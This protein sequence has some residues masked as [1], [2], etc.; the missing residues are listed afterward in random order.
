[1]V[2]QLL[3]ITSTPIEY[4][5]KIEPARLEFNQADNP[6]GDLSQQNVRLNL[7]SQNTQ[8]RLDTMDMRRTLG[9]QTSMDRAYAGAQKGRS[10]F[11]KFLAEQTQTAN[12]LANGAPNGTKIADVVRQRMLEQPQSY[13][14]FLPSTGPDISW[15]PAELN[16]NYQPGGVE[17]DWQTMR[18]VM[19]YVP[20]K[21]HMEIVQYPKV[22]VEYLGEP[23]Y[24]PRSSDPNYVEPAE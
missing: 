13:T 4:Q 21:Y 24:I 19:E 18:N 15:V 9:F 2:Q 16:I 5:L 8:V 7:N 10:N 12:A 11:Q 6:K 23:Q 1:M 20:G 17:M 3:Q 14:A 22:E